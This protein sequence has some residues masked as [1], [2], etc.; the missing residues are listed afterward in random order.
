MKCDVNTIRREKDTAG[1]EQ[2]MFIQCD[3]ERVG[4][5][6]TRAGRLGLC[7]PCLVFIKEREDAI[8]QAKREEK[9]PPAAP[10]RMRLGKVVCDERPKST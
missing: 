10:L 9:V 6:P 3:R 7:E 8:S 1:E 2:E 4:V 5:Y